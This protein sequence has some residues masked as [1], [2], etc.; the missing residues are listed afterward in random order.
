MYEIFGNT[1]FLLQMVAGDSISQEQ[2]LH[3]IELL[4]KVIAPEVRRRVAE[5]KAK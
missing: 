5:L 2:I 1:R 3:S 4:G